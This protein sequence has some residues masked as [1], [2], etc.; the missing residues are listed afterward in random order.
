MN[1]LYYTKDRLNRTREIEVT[2]KINEKQMKLEKLK[3]MLKSTNYYL[4]NSFS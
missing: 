2:S 4:K 3:S 1:P